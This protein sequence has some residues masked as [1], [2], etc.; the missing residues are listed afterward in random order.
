MDKNTQWRK[1]RR[2]MTPTAKVLNVN[3]EDGFKLSVHTSFHP[4]N[5]SMENVL[6]SGETHYGNDFN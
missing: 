1:Q 2:Y 6:W 4:S 3:V 5:N